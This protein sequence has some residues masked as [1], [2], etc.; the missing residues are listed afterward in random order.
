M[1]GGS[2]VTSA[3]ARLSSVHPHKRVLEAA[4]TSSGKSGLRFATKRAKYLSCTDLPSNIDDAVAARFDRNVI[5]HRV[6][7]A[8]GLLSRLLHRSAIKRHPQPLRRAVPHE[9]HVLNTARS[10]PAA[11][12][13]VAA[14]A[15]I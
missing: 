1:A 4:C 5:E 15:A 14:V 9:A 3:S 7:G 2:P 11:V 13:A 10:S 12:A 8:I 6:G